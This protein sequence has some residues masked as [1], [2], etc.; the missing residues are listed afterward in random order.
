M[1]K[2]IV[3]IVGRPAI[4]KGAL[5]GVKLGENGGFVTHATS[6]PLPSPP[7]GSSEKVSGKKKSFE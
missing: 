3:L 2:N 7:I 6:L 4:I 5:A 1:K